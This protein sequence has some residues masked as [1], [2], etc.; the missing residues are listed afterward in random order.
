M[1]FP[2]FSKK[3]LKNS[4]ENY[5]RSYLK[6]AGSYHGSILKKDMNWQLIG[7]S[8]ELNWDMQFLRDGKKECLITL[9][10]TRTTYA[11]IIILSKELK[12]YLLTNYHLRKN[13]QL[14]SQTL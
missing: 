11:K 2:K 7:F 8:S 3:L 12:L 1:H 14:K 4:L 10:L 13:I 6:M 5:Y 9:V